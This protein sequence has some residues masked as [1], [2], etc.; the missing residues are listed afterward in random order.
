M[1]AH[2]HDAEPPRRPVLFINPRSGG[3]TAAR[4]HLADR[5]RERGIEPVELTAGRRLDELAV[6]AIEDGADALGAAGG[7]GSVA[8][9][10][11]IASAHD[12]PFVCV[13]AGTRNH[14]ARD[15]GLDPHDPA[16]A[17]DAF[18]AGVE[19][20]VDL[21]DVNGRLFLNNVSFGIYGE[22]VRHAGYRDAKV[23]TLLETADEVLGP[24][25]EASGLWVVDDLVE[26]HRDPAVLLVSNNPYAVNRPG[27]RGTRPALDT[28]RLG[29]IA[30]DLPAR[31]PPRVRAWT[32]P[33]LDVTG[34]REVVHAGVDGEAVDLAG[35]LR[36]ALRPAALRVRV[37][38]PGTSVPTAAGT[39]RARSRAPGGG[40]AGRVGRTPRLA[41]A[42]TRSR[43]RRPAARR[44][45][46]G[47]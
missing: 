21:G 12:L 11:A 47:R 41:R 38:E 45:P 28:G 44:W 2:P 5:A 31:R 23:R 20:R 36:I 42:A 10:A 8:T 32:A 9:V 4:E 17:L 13:P 35:Q 29:I 18:A 40:T 1:V 34:D 46:P 33:V 6:E 27:A 15:L 30:V 3:G 19:R 24:S 14:F 22:A 25:G 16:G 26:E 39:G 43:S 37:L 7:D